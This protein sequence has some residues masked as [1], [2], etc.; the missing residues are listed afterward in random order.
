MSKKIAVIRR[1]GYGDL[2]CT[3]P[4]IACL[5]ERYPGA[6]ITLFVGE[7]NKA[8]VPYLFPKHKYVV[9]PPGNKYWQVAKTALKQSS[10]D[11]V[12]AAKP[13]PM[14]LN[15]VF[16]ALLKAKEKMAVTLGK[17][18]HE[19]FIKTKRVYQNEGHQALRSLKI[20]DPSITSIPPSWFP[21][22]VARPFPLSLPRP[23]LFFSLINNR[24]GSQLTLERF[25]AIANRIYRERPFSV[26]LSCKEP[27]LFCHRL[28]MP[29]E[30]IT[31]PSFDAF[32]SLLAGVDAVLTGDGGSCHLAA[33]IGKPQ[34]ALYAT[35]PLEQWSPLS[36]K[37]SCLFHMTDVN[38]IDP[39]LIEQALK[40][41]LF[42]E[43]A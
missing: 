35:T 21:K 19:R 16:L 43:L 4:L 3:A 26:V 1:N 31:T 33:A 22:C 15:N 38:Q 41:A 29:A 39:V 18:W 36:E 24:P 27:V 13:S 20:L 12:I 2:I 40:K 34:V 14:K 25:A 23:I 42:P 6:E 8:L 10:F 17:G 37:A 28:E 5:E 32:L 11:I 30:A 7:H 9:I